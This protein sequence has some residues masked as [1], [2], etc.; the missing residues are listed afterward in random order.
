VS[1]S[2]TVASQLPYTLNYLQEA[3]QCDEQELMTLA[4]ALQL[5]PHNEP[6]ANQLAFTYR[7]AQILRK[8]MELYRRGESL[9]SIQSFFGSERQKD[10]APKTEDLAVSPHERL[11]TNATVLRTGGNS[12][13]AV[14][15][16]AVANARND[17]LTDVAR[18]MD[19][20]LAGLDEVVV[21][22]IRTKAENDTLKA[23]LTALEADLEDAENDLAQFKPTGF[24]FYR[25]SAE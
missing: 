2:S 24:G 1:A 16:E 5:E 18:L 13:L 3:L 25:K 21:E 6:D 14:V 10:L 19:D 11:Q 22:L 9:K 15:V 17:I 8:G 7:E 23:K 20:K 12:N 4:S